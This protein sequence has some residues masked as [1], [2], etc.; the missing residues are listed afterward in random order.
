M[1]GKSKKSDAYSSPFDD[2]ES[3]FYHDSEFLSKESRRIWGHERYKCDHGRNFSPAMGSVEIKAVGEAVDGEAQPSS[4]A[5]CR[6]CLEHDGDPG[7]ELIAPCQ[8]KGTQQF[9]HRSCLDHWRSVKEGFAFT[10]C[11]TC[12]AQFHLRINFLEGSCWR[13]VKFRMFVARD[14]I[15]VFLAVQMIISVLGGLS[16]LCDLDGTFRKSIGHGWDRIF[17]NHPVLF[18]YCLGAVI[19]LALVGIFGLLLQCT[20]YSVHNSQEYGS[21]NRSSPA[22][23]DS[24]Y[25]CNGPCIISCPNA[26]PEE[27]CCAVVFVIIIVLVVILAVAGIFYGIFGATICLQRILQKHHYILTKRELTKEYIVEDLCG[28][29][30]PPKLDEEHADR[31]RM[32]NLL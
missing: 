4:A 2:E 21:Y 8:C 26:D 15:L 12:R 24:I 1:K 29:Y 10:H 9:V 19:F 28:H 14:I 7:D 18:Y 6:I 31:L 32:L 16:Y 23:T 30:T 11:T 17:S 5:T 27:D 13:T 22:Q 25:C 3:D 20:S